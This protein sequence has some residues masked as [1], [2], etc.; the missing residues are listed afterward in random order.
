MHY[1]EWDYIRKGLLANLSIIQNYYHSRVFS[2]KSNHFLSR[3]INT[4]NVPHTLELERYYD[5]VDTKSD[6]LSMHMKMT[7]SIYRGQIH[8]G[9]FYGT[10]NQEVIINDSTSYDPN[11]VH[12]NWKYV[13]PVKVLMHPRSDLALLLPNGKD[14][15]SETG[16]AVISINIPML[17][18]QF[19]AF[20]IDQNYREENNVSPLTVAN[21]IAKYILPNMLYSHIDLAIFNRINNYS[22]GAPLGETKYKH[23]FITIDYTEKIDRMIPR[24]IHD[25]NT[26]SVNYKMMMK[27]IPV[28]VKHDLEEVM[29]LPDL[30]PTRQVLWAELIS[31]IDLIDF[32]TRLGEPRTIRNNGVNNSYFYREFKR[33]ERDGGL[34]SYLPYG[35]YLDLKYKM[36]DVLTRLNQNTV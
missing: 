1:P 22:Q 8:K 28:I 25:I 10:E 32:I 3:L 19:R 15:G 18:V 35:V 27:N 14:T 5:N 16:M 7:S 11:W 17:A 2:V 33:Y 9:I 6:K 30:A 13:S 23:P 20:C 34:E 29:M 36:N 26:K 24:I 4:I 21:F 12:K 31:R